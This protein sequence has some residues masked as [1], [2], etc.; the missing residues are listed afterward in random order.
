VSTTLI[1]GG[2]VITATRDTVEDILIEDGKIARLGDLA[3][4]PADRVVDASGKLVIP[5]GIAPHTHMH[6]PAGNTLISDDC[7]PRPVAVASPWSAR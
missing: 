5:G 7:D 2:R 4:F 6:T 3:D 1:T